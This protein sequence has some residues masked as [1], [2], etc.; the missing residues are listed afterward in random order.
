MRH[1]E[2]KADG[3]LRTSVNSN[4][5]QDK[6]M[7]KSLL[8]VAHGSRRESS[9]QEV[10]ELAARLGE[11]AG[12]YYDWVTCAF[13]ELAKPSIPDGIDGCVA[14]GADQV[15]VLPYFLVAGRHVVEDIP[16]LVEPR[17]VVHP[18]VEITIAPYLGATPGLEELLLARA[19]NRG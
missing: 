2:L 6:H 5:E 8:L 1:S 9:N 7:K 16:A 18:Q 19:T 17:R 11:R 3:N 15:V 13:L 10:R 12:G 4:H 14:R